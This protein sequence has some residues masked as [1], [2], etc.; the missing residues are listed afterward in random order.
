MN[1]HRWVSVH[2]A[3]FLMVAMRKAAEETLPVVS[4]RP[5]LPFFR[6]GGWGFYGLPLLSGLS[7]SPAFGTILRTTGLAFGG[8]SANRKGNPAWAI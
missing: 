1:R 3:A 6:Y 4:R 8:I 5:A 7:D 2:L